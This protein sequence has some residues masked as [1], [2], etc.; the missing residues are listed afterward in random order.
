MKRI[1]IIFGMLAAMLFAGSQAAAVE[2]VE[3]KKPATT[4]PTRPTTPPP[5]P[6]TPPKKPTPPKKKYDDFIDKNK[7]GVDDRKES[8]G[9]SRMY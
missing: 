7:N 6:A 3:K 1:A 2:K 5:K 9:K 4:Q 8:P